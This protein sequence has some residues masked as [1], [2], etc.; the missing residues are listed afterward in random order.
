[1]TRNLALVAEPANMGEQL[2]RNISVML[3]QEDGTLG[4]LPDFIVFNEEEFEIFV[5]TSD[6]EDQGTYNVVVT[7]EF[8]DYP[9]LAAIQ[10]FKVDVFTEFDFI[11][12]RNGKIVD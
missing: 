3:L 2:S 12:L 6:D 4:E 7:V 5:S 10:K 1:M 8:P 11:A 9:G